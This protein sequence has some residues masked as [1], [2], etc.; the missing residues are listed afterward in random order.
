RMVSVSSMK[1]KL[2]S[3][4]LSLLPT[5]SVLSQKLCHFFV[6]FERSMT[7]CLA[8]AVF[9]SISSALHLD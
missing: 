5:P 2:S 8:H 7:C 9:V 1:S 3:F 6:S 4:L